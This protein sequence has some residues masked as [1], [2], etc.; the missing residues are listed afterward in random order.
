MEKLRLGVI[1]CGGMEKTH[2]SAYSNVSNV[3]VTATC[4]IIR[5]RAEIAAGV[6]G[7]DFFCTDFHD[8]L[9]RVDA[10]LLVLPHN[11]HYCIGKECLLAGKHVLMEKPFC[12]N[13]AQC[14]ELA[15]I[16]DEKNLVLMTAYCMRFHPMVVKLKELIDSK[17]YGDTF[18]VSIWTE[19]YTR[20]PCDH[21]ASLAA[22]LGGG[23][24]FS[25]G[26][27]YIDLLL[28]F[29]GEPVKGTHVGTNFGTP[30]MEYEGTS[31]VSIQFANGALG[32]HFGT[33]GAKG[34]KLRYSIHAHCTEGMIDCALSDGRM[35]LNRFGKEPEIIMENPMSKN[36]QYEME[37]FADCVLNGKKPL[38]G[39]DTSLQGLR[40]IWRM[41][42][43]ERTDRVADLRG[44][45]FGDDWD[46]ESPDPNDRCGYNVY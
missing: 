43:A 27:H 26:C 3:E 8:L 39:V 28:W 36:V 17:A 22:T 5:E 20:Y 7:C 1:G 9:D 19:Q 13:E 42:N 18:Q 25:H 4:D 23:Q 30:W 37:H 44:L 45:G 16:A 12:N 21:W 34:S 14:R 35:T 31:N 41:Y 32:Y 2:Q 40:C 11:L 33:W 46:F 24:L 10:V 29:L 15:H 6:F 38:T